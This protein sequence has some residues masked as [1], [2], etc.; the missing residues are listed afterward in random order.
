MTAF[1]PGPMLALAA[2]AL[3]AVSPMFMA[4]AGRRIGSFPV[5]LLRSL[6]ASLGLAVWIAV[7]SLWAGEVVPMPDARQTAWLAFSGLLGMGIGDA[8]IYEAFVTLGPRRTT[9]TLV[10]TPAFTV[11]IGWLSIGETLSIGTLVGIA[12]ILLATSYAVL[13]GRR[14]AA[15]APPSAP[16]VIAAGESGDVESIDEEPPLPRAAEPGSVTVAGILFAVGGALCMAIGAVTGRQAFADGPPVDTHFATFIRVASAGVLIWLAPL[17]R[18]RALQT[19]ALLRDR[20]I[21]SRIAIG[22]VMGPFIGMSCYV[23]S[24]KTTPVGLVS[25]LVATSPL[26]AIPVTMLRYRAKIGW[27]VIAAAA[28]AVAGAGLLFFA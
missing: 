6:M 24:L 5:L 3:W 7:K 19:M 17:I 16:E 25:T 2:A 4:S 14:A 23:A 28:I 26:F 8:L 18:R 11:V 9:Q 10:I 22:T 20:H 12:V 15:A 21:L 27:D 13:A 1:G